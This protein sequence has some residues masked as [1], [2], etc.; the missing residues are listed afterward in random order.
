MILQMMVTSGRKCDNSE[1][2]K[3]Y[4]KRLFWAKPAGLSTETRLWRGG[5]NELRWAGGRKQLEGFTKYVRQVRR[6][7]IKIPVSWEGFELSNPFLC[8][9]N[10]SPK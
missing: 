10:A 5:K 4:A 3:D 8:V 6:K 7:K 2:G 9:I 1:Q